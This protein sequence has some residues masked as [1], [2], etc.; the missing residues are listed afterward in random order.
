MHYRILH[1]VGLLLITAAVVVLTTGCEHS[2]PKVGLY[3]ASE[4][5][6]DV[7]TCKSLDSQG[8][9]AELTD[10]FMPDTDPYIIVAAQLRPDTPHN[11]GYI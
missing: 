7:F 4:Q 3:P 10:K 11:L 6:V 5:I 8:N 9:W 2:A 1:P